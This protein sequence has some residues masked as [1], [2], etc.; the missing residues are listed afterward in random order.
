MRK[1]KNNQPIAKATN[2]PLFGI[3]VLLIIGIVTLAYFLY[4]KYKEMK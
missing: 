3:I 4:N 1:Q 2:F